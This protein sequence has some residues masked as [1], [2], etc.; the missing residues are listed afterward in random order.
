MA[1]TVQQHVAWLDV[2]VQHIRAMKKLQSLQKLPNDELFVNVRQDACSNHEMQVC[3]HVV[4]SQ[5]NISIVFC[6][7]NMLQFDN[8]IVTFKFLLT[9]KQNSDIQSR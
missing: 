4:K 2:S 7:D 3:L 6:L 8:V 1:V 5:I 9:T